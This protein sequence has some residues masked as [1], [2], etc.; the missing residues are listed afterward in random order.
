MI[1]TRKIQIYPDAIARE[2]LWKVSYLCK[3][4]ANACIE[5]RR[6]KKSW[7]KVGKFSQKKELPELKKV[8]PEFKMPAS[9][10]LQNAV[11][12]VDRSYQM[13]F[14]KRA[15]GD[16]D[17]RPPK[18]RS[19]QYFFTQEYS[20]KGTSFDFSETGFLK[21]AYGKSRRDWIR[22]RVPEFGFDLIETVKV[23]QDKKNHKWYACMTYKV[24]EKDKITGS[25]LY[26]GPGC[27]TSLTGLK[28]TGEF[29]DYDFNGLRKVNLSTYR[30]ID[31]LKSR[32]DKIKNR[33]SKAWRRLNKRIKNL[34]SKIQTRT[35]TYLH[36]L[37]NRVL[38]DHPDVESFKIGDWDKRKT[39]ANTGFKMVNKS[40]NRAVQNNNPLGK[41][42]EILA[43]K[44]KIRGQEVKKF[45]ERGST[46]TC[47]ACNHAHKKGIAPSKRS[48]VCDKCRFIYPR[49]QH[50][51]LNFLKRYEPAVW[52]R[53]S[54]YGMDSRRL[55]LAPFSFKPQVTLWKAKLQAS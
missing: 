21:L 22:I 43:Y 9:Q 30:F 42:I 16:M 17:A 37:A 13:F 23:C 40:I 26:F 35:K 4:V 52:P 28:T 50:S 47:N 38:S 34:F 51:C 36:T 46:R 55:E 5:Q 12:S 31:E 20:Q 1:L 45:D 8:Y 18:F 27:K 24:K 54:I 49:D 2:K 10:V 25:R 33:K 14:T 6:D 19:Y 29:F 44:A 7:G 32:K 39:L 53:L 48:F 41:L 15:S 3:E 11:F